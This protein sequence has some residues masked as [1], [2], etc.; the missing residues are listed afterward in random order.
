MS[1]YRSPFS[2]GLIITIVY[3]FVLFP[4]LVVWIGDSPFR[5][6]T[7]N[8]IGEFLA[9]AFTPLALVWLAVAVFL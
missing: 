7:L 3:F 6:L 2:W 5:S 8:E 9:G 1:W 4:I